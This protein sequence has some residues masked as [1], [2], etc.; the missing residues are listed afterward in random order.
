[1]PNSIVNILQERAQSQPDKR[2][3]TFLQNGAD[4]SATLTFGEM[5]ERVRAL[6]ARLQQQYAPGERALLLYPDSLEYIIA[7]HACLFAGLVAV[8]AFPP[9]RNRSDT[10]LQAI[11]KN[12][13]ASV[14]LIPQSMCDDLPQRLEHNPELARMQ[15]LVTDAGLDTHANQWRPIDPKLD[16]LAYLQYTSGSTG[17]AKGAMITHGNIMNNSEAVRIIKDLWG[18]DTTAV[19][20]LPIFHD[21]GLV[22]VILQAVYSA[23]STALMPSNVFVQ[24]PIRWLQAISRYQATHSGGPD[25]SYQLCCQK[26]SEE[27]LETLDLSSWKDAYSGAESVRVTTLRSFSDYFSRCGFN[28]RSFSPGYGI[29]ENTLLVSYN[30]G[31]Q[32]RYCGVDARHFSLHGEVGED[33]FVTDELDQVTGDA[34]ESHRQYIVSCG[35]IAHGVEQLLM[36]WNRE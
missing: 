17:D 9:R 3:Y 11:A 24:K 7:F 23:V 31:H 13:N 4:E 28:P 21:L 20:W 16:T 14:A 6:A 30:T 8:P 33:V 5:E 35:T 12:A 2:L 10:R 36:V 1:M 18:E 15:F 26:V 22:F 25:F 19:S 32:P 29:A 34:M 27:E